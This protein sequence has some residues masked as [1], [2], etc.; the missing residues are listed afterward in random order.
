MKRDPP[1]AVLQ[2]VE[3]PILCCRCRRFEADD[4]PITCVALAGGPCSACRERATIRQKIKQLEEELAKLKAKHDTVTATM[5]AIHDPFI[6]KLPPEIGSHI[7]RL[8]LPALS[9]GEHLEAT[10][11]L[12]EDSSSPEILRFGA[13]C[14]MWRQLA[15]TTPGL[16]N[17]LYLR[18]GLW[19]RRSLVESLPGLVSEWLKRSG[20]LPL[21]IF[22]RH[23]PAYGDE[24]SD[25]DESEANRG[26]LDVTIRLVIETLNLHSQRWQ[27]LDLATTRGIF[28]RF[29]SSIQPNQLVG[30]GLR[31]CD[32]Y[33][34]SPPSFMME[35]E[36]SPTHLM[37]RDFPLTSVNIRWDNITH[38]TLWDSSTEECIDALR[39]APGLEYYHIS[40]H[41]GCE[42]RK[43]IVHSDSVRSIC[44]HPMILK[45]SSAESAFHLSKNGRRIYAV[46]T[47]P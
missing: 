33:D 38:L 42:I 9:N 21:T 35:S 40:I 17:T 8:C 29:S 4:E 32:V 31:L 11:N 23:Y 37:L 14:R 25:E 43:P 19:T 47:S 6:H 15:W 16:W 27:N 22:F 30:L 39:R 41:S 10:L 26:T 12:Q 44:Q 45:T 18:I 28:K 3:M 34:F 13:V 36:L 2:V 7:F 5:N 1:S 24:S 20:S 46:K